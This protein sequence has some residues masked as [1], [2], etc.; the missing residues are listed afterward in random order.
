MRVL[1]K[2]RERYPEVTL[3]IHY[4]Y[5]H[6]R[7][8]GVPHLEQLAVL[9][10]Q[11]IEERPWVKYHGATQQDKLMDSY[12]RSAFCLQPSDWIET[13]MISAMELICCGVYPIM[14]NLGGV[15][16]TLKWAVD[17]KMA[18]LVDDDCITES[19]Y[20]KYIEATLDAIENERW[21]DVRVDPDK[22]SWEAVAKEWLTDLPQL[23]NGSIIEQK[24]A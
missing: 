4:G 17:N 15:T 10:D 16:D 20:I 8:C 13:S 6:I 3:H 14:R 19:Q 7:K 11:M 5:E 21:M 9:L 24:R 18:T 2:V 23:I 22:L 1:D 12:K